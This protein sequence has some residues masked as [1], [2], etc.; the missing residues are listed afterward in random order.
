MSHKQLIPDD[1]IAALE[2]PLIPYYTALGRFLS[3]YALVEAN[4][5]YILRVCANVSDAVGKSLFSGTRV[6]AAIEYLA[7]IAEAE[8]WSKEKRSHLDTVQEQ[9]GEL[10]RV[11]N[12]ILHYGASR[13][14]ID[15]EWFTTNAIVA[16]TQKR[17][18]QT[19]ITPDILKDMTHDCYKIA[20]HITLVGEGEIS[21][22]SLHAIGDLLSASW[23]YKPEK[24]IFP[25]EIPRPPR[26][27]RPPPPQ[28]SDE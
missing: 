24:P 13:T 18:R 1:F 26:P 10:T 3:A 8:T 25:Q 22:Y 17:L 27:K 6:T 23:R 7:R 11:R 12:D 21:P 14:G 4:A 16:H 2:A 28:P 5:Q 19:R 20:A 15:G 9:L